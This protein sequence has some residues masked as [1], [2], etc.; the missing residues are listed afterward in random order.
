VS[1]EV[2][3]AVK[4]AFQLLLERDSSIQLTITFRDPVLRLLQGLEDFYEAIRDLLRA[5][6]GRGLRVCFVPGSL[7]LVAHAEGMMHTAARRLPDGPRG[8]VRFRWLWR[9][10]C[11]L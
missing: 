5:P 4:E 1:E 8:H 7:L 3:E 10:K 9:T 11:T 6:R 2:V